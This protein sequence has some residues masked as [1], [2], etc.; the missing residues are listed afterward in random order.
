[1]VREFNMF[2]SGSNSLLYGCDFENRNALSSND[3]DLPFT[4]RQPRVFRKMQAPSK[5]ALC[6]DSA[7]AM[8]QNLLALLPNG[9]FRCP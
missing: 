8:R 5:S 9:G 1:M 3:Q 4:A 7:Y 2:T 6:L